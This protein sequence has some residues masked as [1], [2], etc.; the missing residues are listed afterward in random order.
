MD[1]FTFIPTDNLK[2]YVIKVGKYTPVEDGDI[3]LLLI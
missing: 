3:H 1:F 2:V